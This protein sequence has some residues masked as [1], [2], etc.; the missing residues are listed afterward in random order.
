MKNKIFFILLNFILS[1][2]T[3]AEEKFNILD[4]VDTE[5]YVLW[6]EMAVT[7]SVVEAIKTFQSTNEALGVDQLNQDQKKMVSIPLSVGALATVALASNSAYNT[8][9][10]TRTVT[11]QANAYLSKY[12]DQVSSLDDLV[13]Y[14][15]TH[16]ARV[17][18]NKYAR[19]RRVLA[20]QNM[21][22]F[23]ETT[24][25]LK[26]HITGSS[27]ASVLSRFNR[28]ARGAGVAVVGALTTGAYLAIIGSTM[29]VAFANEM[30]MQL[31][32]EKFSEDIYEIAEILEVSD[33][34]EIAGAFDTIPLETGVATL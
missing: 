14:G 13:E 30:E 12:I 11:P 9:G 5:E 27:K 18:R 24:Q 15:S 19:A 25:Q 29:T 16:S 2:Y 8:I 26:S 22:Q 17:R 6:A 20:Q 33:G 32:L 34:M 21:F 28:V 1:N 23:Q 3:L 4:S 7:H 10:S 31:V